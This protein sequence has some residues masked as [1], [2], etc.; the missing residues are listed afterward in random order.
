MPKAR[1][2]SVTVKSSSSCSE[3]F[4]ALNVAFCSF[5]PKVDMQGKKTAILQTNCIKGKKIKTNSAWWD[6]LPRLSRI[7]KDALEI[8]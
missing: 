4:V 1:G 8:S 3:A 2:Q 6:S 7:C 5:E